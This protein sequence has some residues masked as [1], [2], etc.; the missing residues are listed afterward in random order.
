MRPSC[1]LVLLRH[2]RSTGSLL[3]FAARAGGRFS[4]NVRFE[5]YIAITPGVRSGKPCI[6]GA[7]I[8]VG[9][10]LEYLAC[11]MTE[12]EILADFPALRPGHIRACLAFAAA[13]N[14]A[15]QFAQPCEAAL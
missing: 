10:V 7:R 1:R 6:R 15:L 14:V 4:E 3:A 5:D 8:T 12:A 13:G 2:Y 11:G 9:D